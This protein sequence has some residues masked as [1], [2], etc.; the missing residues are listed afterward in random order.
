MGLNIFW[1]FW[2]RCQ[3]L[4]EKAAILFY[5][6]EGRST[7]ELGIVLIFVNMLAATRLAL[8][9]RIDSMLCTPYGLVEVGW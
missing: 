8:V 1:S 2:L 6:N 9:E 5:A 3:Q 7:K 4:V